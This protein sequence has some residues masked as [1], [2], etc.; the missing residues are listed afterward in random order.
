[1]D[2]AQFNKELSYKVAKANGLE[3]HNN[4]KEAIRIWVDISEMA[5]KMSKTPNLDFSYKSMLMEKTE[6]IIAHIKDLK[7]RLSGGKEKESVIQKATISKSDYLDTEEE[8]RNIESAPK[9]E[10]PSKVSNKNEEKSVIENSDIKNLPIGFK[11]IKVSQ[12]FKIITPHNEDYVNEMLKKEVNM[13]IFSSDK[14]KDQSSSRIEFE[15]PHEKGK[16]TCFACGTEIPS[17]SRKCP[18]CGTELVK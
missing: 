13:D 15:Q 7:L 17:N 10:V 2:I 9:K 18:N 11:E 14:A 3:K 12:D 6:Q 1:M 8:M 16:M 5:L 4:L